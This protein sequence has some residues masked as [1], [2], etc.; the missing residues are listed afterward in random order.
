M[1]DQQKEWIDNASYEKLLT[2]W[3]FNSSEDTIFHG[4]AGNY[5][6]AVMD[7]KKEG[8]DFVTIS[9]RVG[10]LGK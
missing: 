10:W 8:V 2:K 3:R 7:K 4:D 1:T 9:K 5:Y 6:I